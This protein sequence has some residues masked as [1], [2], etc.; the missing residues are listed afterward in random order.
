MSRH[1]YGRDEESLGVEEIV[2]TRSHARITYD[3]LMRYDFSDFVLE[4]ANAS[5][6]TPEKIKNNLEKLGDTVFFVE[7]TEINIQHILLGPYSCS[8]CA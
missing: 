4:K 3:I 6:A 5:S 8:R 7:N 2:R 1:L